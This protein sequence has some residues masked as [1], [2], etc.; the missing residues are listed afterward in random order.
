MQEDPTPD[1]SVAL[2]E[3]TEIDVAAFHAGVALGIIP[4]N[5]SG[6]TDYNFGGQKWVF[7]TENPIGSMLFD[8]LAKMTSAGILEQ[9]PDDDQLYRW[10]AGF[11]W[12]HI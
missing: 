4:P 10:N 1:L 12:D 11:D 7:W 6:K 9:R 2:K 8:L 5:V 3:W